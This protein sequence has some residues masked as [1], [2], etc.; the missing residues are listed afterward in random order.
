MSVKVPQNLKIELAYATA[1]PLLSV[2][3]KESKSAHTAA[4]FTIAKVWK[5][6]RYPLTNELIKK[7]WYV[8]TVECY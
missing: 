1:M 3:V 8:Y 5:Q 6:S 7:I 2:P 4:P